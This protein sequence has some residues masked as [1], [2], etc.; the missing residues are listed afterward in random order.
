MSA[1]AIGR[2]DS[3]CT[4]SS[5][6]DWNEMGG[7]HCENVFLT[8]AYKTPDFSSVSTS[9]LYVL[10]HVSIYEVKMTMSTSECCEDLTTKSFWTDS[11]II[12]CVLRSGNVGD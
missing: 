11:R 7:R 10:S 8:Y 9:P 12:D 3:A 6:T 5:K 1:L 4:D 2:A